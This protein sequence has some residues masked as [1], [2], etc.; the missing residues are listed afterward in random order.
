A[1]EREQAAL[2]EFRRTLE[3][4]DAPPLQPWDIAFYAEKQR[5]ALY[6]F[7][8][9]ALRPYFVVDRVLDG[10]FEIVH[11]LYGISVRDNRTMPTWHRSVRAYDVYDAEE[12]H[13][14]AFY[15]DLYPRETKR[16]G[17]WMHG[18]LTGIQTEQG[19]LTP[20]LGLICGNMTPPV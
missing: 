7:D 8:E 17:A 10:L 18:L 4:P 9:E 20:H 12:T 16:D 14:A 11:R 6:A 2:M 15:V 13:L 19:D 5:K 3:G 1:F